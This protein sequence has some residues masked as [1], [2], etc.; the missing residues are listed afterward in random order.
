[1]VPNQYE[2][3]Y[4]SRRGCRRPTVRADDDEGVDVPARRTAAQAKALDRSSPLPLWAQLHA[5]LL[6]RLRAGAFTGRFPGEVQ[7]MG[8]YGVSRHTVREAVRR[9]RDEG[10][11][12]GARGRQSTV[13]PDAIEQ[14]VGSLYSL[15][16]AV[17]ARGMHQR[18]EVL[19]KEVAPDDV[20]A[21]HLGLAP[22][23][24]L[25][26]LER[27][28]LADDEPLARDRVWLPAEAARPLLDADF[29]HV[30]LYDELAERCGIRLRGGS[31]RI[32]AA[33]P[34][35]ALRQLL[36]LPDDVACLS[37][38]RIGLRRNR[39]FEY[40]LT[41]IRGDRYAVL[42]QWSSQ[43]YRVGAGER[44]EPAPGR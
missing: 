27:L 41:D 13:R 21:A 29:T 3:P 24:P 22:D 36:R 37:I 33:V 25:F 43:G 31:E 18:S 4:I 34:D 10:F 23:E 39:P 12:T 2:C 26:H 17:E 16:R 9:L 30:A 20:A 19:A 15:F 38:E 42:T 8:E 5:D 32:T 14:P 6:R 35:P 28:R 11:V 1:M 7:L 40:R 44:V